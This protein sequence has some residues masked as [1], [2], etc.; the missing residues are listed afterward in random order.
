MNMCLKFKKS[1]YFDI[2]VYTDAD[3]ANDLDDRRSISG[4]YVFLGE[5]LIAWSL[6]K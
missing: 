4:Y 5:N 6:R 2:I 1:E 3:W